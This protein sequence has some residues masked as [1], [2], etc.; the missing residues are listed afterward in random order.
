LGGAWLVYACH[1]QCGE[2]G[3]L[4][5][6][7]MPLHDPHQENVCAK[8]HKMK[9]GVAIVS[10]LINFIVSKGMNHHEF[11]DSFEQYGIQAH[12]CSLLYRS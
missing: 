5:F 8:F 10:K 9:N 11:K 3:K 6:D 7:S 2:Y 12:R 1:H 4:G